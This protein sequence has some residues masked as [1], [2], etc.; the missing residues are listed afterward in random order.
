MPG[1]II[2]IPSMFRKPPSDPREQA[3]MADDVCI[4]CGLPVR[5]HFS[6]ANKPIGCDGAKYRAEYPAKN[7][8]RWNDPYPAVTCA[9]RASL[10]MH[11]GPALEIHCA[12]YTHDELLAIAH[13]LSKDII[14]AYQR[15]I[16][17]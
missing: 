2:H 14:A 11:C 1:Q 17:K 8:E 7:P 10:L 3:V 4:A 9:A 5:L 16:A 12:S 15:E 6:L 13:Q